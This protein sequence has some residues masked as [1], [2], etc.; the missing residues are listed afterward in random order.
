MGIP[1]NLMNIMSCLVFLKVKNE[2][3]LLHVIVLSWKKMSIGFNLVEKV[4]G[5]FFKIYL[6]H[7]RNTPIFIHDITMTSFWFVKQK[8]CE[9]LK[10]W[11][12][13]WLQNMYTPNSSLA[14]M[15]TDMLKL[16]LN[17]LLYRNHPSS[18][19]LWWLIIT[20]QIAWLDFGNG[21]FKFLPYLL[22]MVGFWLNMALTGN[23]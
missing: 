11:T 10:H 15:M 22:W 6:I 8:L 20:L 18:E 19:V 12:N 13:S 4:E 17:Y 9:L 14:F 1:K 23:G 5:F 3:K 2:Q 7:F 16:L 21:S